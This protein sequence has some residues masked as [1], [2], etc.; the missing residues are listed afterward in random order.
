MG[1]L[2][3]S[4][5]TPKSRAFG[6]TGVDYAGSFSIKISRNKSGKAY[7]CLFVCM[8]TKAIHLE[9]VSDLSTEMFL[10]ALKRFISRRGKCESIMSDNGRNFI[11]AT[12]VKAVKTHLKAV[13]NDTPLSFEELYTVLTQIEAILNSRPLCPLTNAPE[14]LDALTPGHFLIGTSFMALP[15]QSVLD[16]PQNRINRYQLLTHIQQSF[17]KRWSREYV[18][19]L[20]QRSKWKFA[21]RNDELQLGKL[22]IIRDETSPPFR[23][24]LGRICEL[25]AGNDG[26]IRVMSLKTTTGIIQRSLPKICILPID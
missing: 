23:W 4:K 9:L 22:A 6:H 10:N 2:P 20:Q 7:L 17:W 8:T 1:D 21:V 24:R 14:E 12:N 11:E 5:V 16:V 25:H 15:E 19:Q 18:T 3:E 26:L 13:I